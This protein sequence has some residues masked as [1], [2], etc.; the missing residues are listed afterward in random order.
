MAKDLRRPIDLLV[1]DVVLPRM[2]G[3]ELAEELRARRP[4]LRVLFIS[5]YTG[6]HLAHLPDG[7]HFLAKPFGARDLLRRAGEALTDAP[8]GPRARVGTA[9]DA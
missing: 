5:G 8:G 7:V 3:V 4:R 2:S 6:S 1:S 9:T